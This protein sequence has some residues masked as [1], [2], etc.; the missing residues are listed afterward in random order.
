L[1]FILIYA[2]Y[3]N[4]VWKK[5]QTYK[6]KY[7]ETEELDPS[8]VANLNEKGQ[9][10][11][12]IKSLRQLRDYM[13]DGTEIEFVERKKIYRTKDVKPT[14]SAMSN[15]KKDG[16]PGAPATAVAKPDAKQ[17]AAKK[18]AEKNAKGNIVFF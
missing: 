15:N 11:L 10:D 8:E 18:K 4:Q 14:E 7:L 12:K 6:L 3:K 16:K 2:D 5:N 9:L 17:E 1:N 13:L